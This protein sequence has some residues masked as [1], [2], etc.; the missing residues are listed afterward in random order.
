MDLHKILELAPAQ[1]ERF[2]QFAHEHIHIG[3][4]YEAPDARNGTL[5][6]LQRK[7]L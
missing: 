4:G 5:S 6:L 1:P 2:D 7:G 3:A